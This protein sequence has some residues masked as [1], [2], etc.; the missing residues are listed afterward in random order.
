MELASRD[1]VD[2]LRWWER[3]LGGGRVS[4][5]SVVFAIDAVVLAVM[6]RLTVARGE[7]DEDETNSVSPVQM[8]F[9]RGD[10]L[11]MS[12]YLDPSRLIGHIE[13]LHRVQ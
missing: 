12:A 7:V 2:R 9:Q 4:I 5:S 1:L 6:V 13:L 10:S 3:S 8:S 11:D